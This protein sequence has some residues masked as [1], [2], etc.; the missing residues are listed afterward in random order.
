MC[1]FTQWL[2]HKEREPNDI[3]T[4]SKRKRLTPQV[5]LDKLKKLRKT[6]K[7]GDLSPKQKKMVSLSF[8]QSMRGMKGKGGL[9][10]QRA[11][12][13]ESIEDKNLF[14]KLMPSFNI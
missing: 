14:P 4:E 9:K 7:W 1:S 2:E 11:A 5:R 8:R 12:T 10:S 3:L 6:S 13:L